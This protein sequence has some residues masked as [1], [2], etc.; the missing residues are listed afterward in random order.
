MKTSFIFICLAVSLFGFSACSQLSNSETEAVEDKNIVVVFLKNPIQKES[1]TD[2]IF[3]RPNSLSY[4]GEDLIRNDIR[5]NNPSRNDTIIV[6]GV[7]EFMP[8]DLYYNNVTFNYYFKQRDTVV[9]T[10]KDDVPVAEI[11]NRETLPNDANFSFFA[12]K[13]DNQPVKIDDKL[14]YLTLSEMSPEEAVKGNYNKYLKRRSYL[15]SLESNKLVSPNVK[16]FYSEQN[17]Y[18]FVGAL[19]YQK[20]SQIAAD[21]L[22]N[23]S[24]DSMINDETLLYSEFFHSFLDR[25][26]WSDDFSV[27]IRTA[28]S[29]SVDYKLLYEKIKTTFSNIKV[30][31]YLLFYCLQKI[32]E[33]GSSE[34]LKDYVAKFKT[35][36]RDT[37]YNDYINKN[38]S[39]YPS[40]SGTTMLA[41]LQGTEDIDLKQ[42]IK[43]SVN[44]V[45]YVD[46]WAS[47]CMPCRAAFPASEKLREDY[48]DDPINFV[49]ISI[50]AKYT[51][52]EKASHNESLSD[53]SNS[54]LLRDAK[55]A[56][57]LKEIALT[58]IPRYLI[59]DKKGS[60]VF[61]NAPSPESPELRKILATYISE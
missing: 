7:Q 26:L 56:D 13:H 37:I 20:Q 47:W 60:L 19:L 23:F 32:Q 51:D 2:N 15:D 24:I 18:E 39:T 17:R 10:F 61:D 33:E 55:N 11:V 43:E 50:D 22:K 8:V 46:L 28:Q 53:Y 16:D 34:S 14:I 42:Y 54:F 40:I 48:K 49:Y 9:F 58:T 44:K 45:L 38:F 41:S 3:A 12:K 57:L 52:W 6:P 36:V 29:I 30:R 1:N 27:K 59:F 21:L 4:Y 35:D 25:Y 5:L 31:N